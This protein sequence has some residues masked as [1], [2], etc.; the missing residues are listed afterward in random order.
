MLQLANQTQ[1]QAESSIR[2]GNLH[3]LCE[4]F[5]KLPTYSHA[6]FKAHVRSYPGSAVC[7]LSNT[8][9]ML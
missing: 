4:N 7:L 8:A 5:F 2:A 1:S 3:Y 6:E 9:N